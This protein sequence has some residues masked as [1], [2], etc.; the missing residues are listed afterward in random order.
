MT[1]TEATNMIKND[2]HL[3]HEYLSGEYRKALKMA[4]SALEQPEIIRCGECKYMM[5]DGRC[6]EFADD[7]IRPSASDFCSYAERQEE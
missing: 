4:I 2:I 7:N 3:H 6:Y 1:R 5:E